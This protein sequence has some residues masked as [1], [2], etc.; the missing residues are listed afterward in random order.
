MAGS[1]LMSPD[2]IMN[3]SSSS[4]NH[5]PSSIAGV[6]V[7][8]PP[9]RGYLLS[10][11]SST[12]LR[13]SGNQT[14]ASSKNQVNVGV[15]NTESRES[16]P[17]D[18]SKWTFS[19]TILQQPLCGEAYDRKQRTARFSAIPV[20]PALIA[21]VQA[22]DENGR[23]VPVEH[24]PDLLCDLEIRRPDGTVLDEVEIG[25]AV[26]WRTSPS[27]VDVEDKG[28]DSLVFSF[29][30]V[31]IPMLGKF[32][33]RINLRRAPERTNPDRMRIGEWLAEARSN[34]FDMLPHSQVQAGDEIVRTPLS[35]KL[36]ARLDR[37]RQN[38]FYLPNLVS[39]STANQSNLN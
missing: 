9:L 4:Q 22:R 38:T 20:V 3:P 26:Y 33:F 37:T 30:Q 25:N 27:L 18:S 28:V 39:P 16:T 10:R 24:Y 34:F 21:R 12:S 32:F 36:Y 7:D 8:L 29:S 6:G 35:L 11:A 2:E 15:G 19:L 17:T 14:G 5:S 13:S 31:Q 23:L 1:P